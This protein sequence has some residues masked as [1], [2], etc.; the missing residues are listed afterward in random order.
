MHLPTE[1][2]SDIAL[3]CGKRGVWQSIYTR[4]VS[5]KF[6]TVH[7]SIEFV[8]TFPFR[9]YSTTQTWQGFIEK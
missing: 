9:V 2:S 4:T 7:E 1:H 5:K 3:R 6:V 8:H